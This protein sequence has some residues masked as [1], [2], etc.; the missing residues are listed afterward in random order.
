LRPLPGCDEIQIRFG[1]G[2]L[3]HLPRRV[4]APRLMRDTT[5]F[6]F[7]PLRASVPLVAGIFQMPYWPF[8]AANFASAFVWAGMLLTLGDVVGET[9]TRVLGLIQ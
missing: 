8:Q 9:V 3:L 5:A 4:N 6:C 1:H 2:R 7:G